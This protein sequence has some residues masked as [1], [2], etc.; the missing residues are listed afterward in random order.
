MDRRSFTKLC[1]LLGISAA[2]PLNAALKLQLKNKRVGIIGAGA[3]GMCTG[4][5]L[6]ELGVEYTLFEASSRIGGRIKE[7]NT[8]ADFPLS[9]GAEWLHVAPSELDRI[10]Q[11]PANVRL[12]PYPKTAKVAYFEDGNL[13]EGEIGDYQDARFTNSS[14][15]GFFEQYLLPEIKSN[16]LFDTEITQ[17]NYADAGVVLTDS[18]QKHYNFDVVVVTVPLPIL[19]NERLRFLPHFQ[20]TSEMRSIKLRSGEELRC[21]LNL[22]TTSIRRF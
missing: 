22:R 9:L 5:L 1:G 12:S 19:R 16:L 7:E 3:A 4:Y 14:W 21:L 11:K 2:F 13:Y 17:V 20:I 10:A 6:K 15:L 18:L 8:F